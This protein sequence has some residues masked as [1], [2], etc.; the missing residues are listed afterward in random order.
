[1]VKITTMEQ[2]IQER[3]C[4]EQTHAEEI[5]YEKIREAICIAF[6]SEGTA[7]GWQI[8]KMLRPFLQ[9]ESSDRTTEEEDRLAKIT[10]RSIAYRANAHRDELEGTLRSIAW[11]L[12]NIETGQ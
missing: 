5:A 1:V 9:S 6:P 3:A 11:A 4:A 7:M 12:E 2:R 8:A 10:A